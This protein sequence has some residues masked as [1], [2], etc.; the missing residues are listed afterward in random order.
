[1]GFFFVTEGGLFASLM[2]LK[3]GLNKSK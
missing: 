1:M 2:I 3:G